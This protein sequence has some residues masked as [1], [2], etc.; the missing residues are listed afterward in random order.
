MGELT[1]TYSIFIFLLADCLYGVGGGDLESSGIFTAST[2]E[3]NH[4]IEIPG[5][6][7][8]GGGEKVRGRGTGGSFLVSGVGREGGLF[9]GLEVAFAFTF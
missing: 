2:G 5:E 1:V 3:Y 9:A 8:T 7:L 6:D 4:P